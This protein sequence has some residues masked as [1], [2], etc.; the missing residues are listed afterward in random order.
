M[1]LKFKFLGGF[2]GCALGDAIGEIAFYCDNKK[3]LVSKVKSSSLVRYTDDTAMAIGLAEA[4]IEKE[5]DI[6]SNQVGKIFHRNYNEEPNRGY[7]MGPPT[8]F[9]TVEQT[10]Q[11]Y[12][13]VAESLFNGSG[14][15]GNGASM[16]IS[17][18]GLFFYNSLNLY[19]KAKL[20]ARATH[21]H[22]LGIDG[23]SVLAKAISIVVPKDPT[24]FK[25]EKEKFNIMN[26]L[27]EFAR[28]EEYQNKLK[29]V[30]E[31]LNQDKSLDY[32]AK[33]LGSNVL[34]FKS[35]PFTIY[36]FLNEPKS[37]KNCLLNT[38]LVSKDRDTVAAMVSGLSGAY[39]G[40]DAIPDEWIEKLENKSYIQELAENLYDLKSN[41]Q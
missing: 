6:K 7:G 11:S 8:I 13:E 23:A 29:T 31:L 35:V 1:N 4:I 22:P 3:E 9:K 37:F 39:L 26:S 2:I 27:I 40:I 18:L 21:T 10:D 16:R 32:C 5:G 17:P 12:T 25:I 38:A 33:T 15:Y 30:K 34:S 36:S 14:S 41:S 28:T 24:T 20:S 19:E